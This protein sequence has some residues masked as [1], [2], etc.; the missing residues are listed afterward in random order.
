MEAINHRF[1]INTHSPKVAMIQED[2]EKN[3]VISRLLFL[4]GKTNKISWRKKLL[5]TK[6]VINVKF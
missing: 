5:T 4:D 6:I 2:T 3:V 1:V